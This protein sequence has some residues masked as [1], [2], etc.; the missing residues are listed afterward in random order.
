MKSVFNEKAFSDLYW[1]TGRVGWLSC[2]WGEPDPTSRP[3][4]H[5]STAV[6]PPNRLPTAVLLQKGS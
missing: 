6:V 3:Y 5:C 4:G 2:F 1:L